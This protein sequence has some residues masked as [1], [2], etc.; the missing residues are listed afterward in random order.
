MA[1]TLWPLLATALGG[2]PPSGSPCHGGTPFLFPFSPR[3]LRCDVSRAL[4][5]LDEMH[6]NCSCAISLNPVSVKPGQGHVTPHTLPQNLLRLRKFLATYS[7]R[8][9]HAIL[10]G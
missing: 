6:R 10:L 1:A 2:T 3:T 5:L 7:H 4:D 9:L 8:C